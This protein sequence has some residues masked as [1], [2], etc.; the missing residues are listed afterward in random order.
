MPALHWLQP[1]LTSALPASAP[2]PLPCS[3]PNIVVSPY[4]APAPQAMHGGGHPP[5]QPPPV[6][7]SW[8]GTLDTALSAS[9]ERPELCS[10]SAAFALLLSIVCS[11]PPCPQYGAYSAPPPHAGMAYGAPPPQ[12]RSAAGQG[13]HANFACQSFA[14][15]RQVACPI[16]LG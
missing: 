15:T 16:R 5:Q 13:L 4:A 14:R 12:V 3:N 10:T 2:L 7:R 1:S 9:V 11:P 8:G 6:R